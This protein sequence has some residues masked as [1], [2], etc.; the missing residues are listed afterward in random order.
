[1]KL[2]DIVNEWKERS[3]IDPTKINQEIVKTPMLHSWA[4]E[5]YVFFKA[6]LA[7]EEK[8]MSRMKYLKRKYF[9]GEMTKDELDQQGWEQFQGLKPSSSE[10]NQLFELDADIAGIEE[11]LA[12]YK[13]GISAMEYILKQIQGREYTLKNLFEYQKYVGA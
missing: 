8:K 6:K 2:E 4:V 9:R 13:T 3:T 1:M 12:Y 10:L 5:H 11:R 7:G